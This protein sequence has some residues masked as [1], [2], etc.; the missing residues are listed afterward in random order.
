MPYGVRGARSDRGSPERMER[1]QDDTND[2]EMVT[3]EAF[4]Q[5][6]RKR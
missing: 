3:K 6:S 5:V 1:R 4:E 2:T